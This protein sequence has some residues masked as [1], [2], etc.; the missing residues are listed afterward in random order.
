MKF[1]FGFSKSWRQ[2]RSIA[3]LVSLLCCG[4][5]PT[6]KPDWDSPTI[7]TST[8]LRVITNSDRAIANVAQQE[9]QAL[10]DHLGQSPFHAL[11]KKPSDCTLYLFKS[12]KEFRRFLEKYK[13]SENIRGFYYTHSQ[14]IFTPVLDSQ[15]K[16]HTPKHPFWS[17]LRHELVHHLH[18]SRHHDRNA[19]FWLSEGLAEWL[20]YGNTPPPD[21]LSTALRDPE[22]EEKSLLTIVTNLESVITF[23]KGQD[24]SQQFARWR[25]YVLV[26][27][28]M[29]HKRLSK[30]LVTYTLHHASADDG[31]TD[32]CEN[33]E[34]S[35]LELAKVFKD[36]RAKTILELCKDP[37]IQEYYRLTKDLIKASD[38]YINTILAQSLK[39]KG[40]DH[41]KLKI[42]SQKRELIRTRIYEIE[43]ARKPGYKTPTK[44]QQSKRQ[45]DK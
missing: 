32:L 21:Y 12:S 2:A 30:K 19:P 38:Q 40:P 43:Q 8:K 25:A 9:Y 28:L 45:A 11:A 5:N 18:W 4:C 13:L 23:R 26:R 7:L 15:Y 6:I 39:G 44:N 24:K 42:M 36:G 10:L 22:R 17:T 1:G 3:I 29:N 14:A 34:S 16:E 41:K 35:H 27:A 31:F 20:T 37:N 33:L